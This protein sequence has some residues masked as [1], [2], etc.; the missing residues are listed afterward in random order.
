[1]EYYSPIKNKEILPFASAW[2]DPEGIM[3]SEIRQTEK[4]KYCIISLVCGIFKKKKKL[5]GKKIRQVVT[6]RRGLGKGDLKEGGQKVRASR[7]LPSGPGV[8]NPP[9]N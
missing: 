4:G 7:D 1:M 2:T 6:R 8:R 3:L 5:I 9:S